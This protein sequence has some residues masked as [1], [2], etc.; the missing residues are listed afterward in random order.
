MMPTPKAFHGDMSETVRG[1]RG[2]GV[3]CELGC[4]SSCTGTYCR[5]PRPTGPPHVSIC[6]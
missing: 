2:T 6:N 5:P 4:L 3:W 1:Q